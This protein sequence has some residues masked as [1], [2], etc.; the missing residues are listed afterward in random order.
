MRASVVSVYSIR[1]R[2]VL[3]IEHTLEL[4]EMR[5]RHPRVFPPVLCRARRQSR[6]HH[7]EFLSSRIREDHRLAGTLQ[8]VEVLE[9]LRDRCS[10]DEDTVVTHHKDPPTAQSARQA[11]SL[12]A[13]V[14]DPAILEILGDAP[15]KARRILIYGLHARIGKRR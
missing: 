12:I 7:L 4:I 15:V 5:E 6:R 3:T 14:G 11:G 8:K 1:V 13:V 9:S 10:D 2:G